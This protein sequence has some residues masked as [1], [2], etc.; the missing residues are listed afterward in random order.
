MNYQGKNK[1][2][3][4]YK[5]LVIMLLMISCSIFSQ[6]VIVDGDNNKIIELEIKGPSEKLSVTIVKAQEIKEYN[7][8]TGI[9]ELSMVKGGWDTDLNPYTYTWYKNGVQMSPQPILDQNNKINGLSHGEYHVIAKSRTCQATSNKINLTNPP[10]LKIS[11]SVHLPIACFEGEG[12]IRALIKG[13][14]SPSSGN[15]TVKLYK[16]GNT[17]ILPI[18]YVSYSSATNQVVDFGPLL[19]GNYRIEVSDKYI[20]KSATV[21]LVEP[22]KLST[23]IITPSD[24]SCNG[25]NDGKINVSITGGTIPYTLILDGIEQSVNFNSTK[26]IANLTAKNYSVQVRDANGCLSTIVPTKLEQPSAIKVSKVSDGNPTFAGASDGFIN[27]SVLGGTGVYFYQWFKNSSSTPFATTQNVSGLKEGSYKVVVTDS[28]NCNEELANIILTDPEPL[29]IKL[30]KSDVKCFGEASGTITANV[31]GGASS[32]YQYEWF[33]VEGTTNTTFG[34]N[35]ASVFNLG[36]GTYKVKVT[37][38][39]AGVPVEQKEK[40]IVINQPIQPLSIQETVA[41]VLCKGG[42]TGSIALNITGGTPGYTYEWSNGATTKDIG[43]LREGNYTVKITDNNRC[44]LEKTITIVEPLQELSVGLVNAQDPLAYGGTD[45][46]ININVTGGTFPYT[47][48]WFKDGATISIASTPN[49]TNIGKGR[50][51]VK[52][53]DTN[54]CSETLIHILDEPDPLVAAITIP[55]DGRLFCFNDT[56]GKMEVA[57]SGGLPP[58]AYHWYEKEAGGG[59]I[60]I[61][62]AT[63]TT[64]TN[65]ASGV[66]GIEVT[67]RNGNGVKT[68]TELEMINPAVVEISSS[69]VTNVACFGDTT[70]AIEV[71]LSGGSSSYLYQWTKQG[72]ADVIGTTNKL[73]NIPVGTYKLKVTDNLNCPNPAIEKTFTITQPEKLEIENDTQVNLSGFETNNGEIKVV[74]VK[75]G[76]LPYAYT[77][78]LK[79]SVAII[80]TTSHVTGLAAATYVMT[81]TDANNC[82][83]QKE[84][85][86]TQPDKLEVT[87]AIAD[88]IDCFGGRG[89]IRSNVSGGFLKTN[90]TYTYQWFDLNNPTTEIGSTFK[91]TNFSG[92]YMVKV[93]DSNGNTAQAQILLPQ[94]NPLAISYT[95]TAVS[96]YNGNDASITLSVT[97]GTNAYRYAWNNGMTTSTITALAAGRY[98]VVVKDDNNCEISATILISEPNEYKATPTVFNTPTGAGLSNGEIA[99]DVI[100]GTAPYQLEWRDED[101]NLLGNTDAIQNLSAGNYT[102]KVTDQLGCELVEVYNLGEPE[103][104][105]VTIEQNEEIQCKGNSQASLKAVANG[106]V[107]GNTYVWYSASTNNVLG[108]GQ[109]IYNLPSGNYYVVVTDFNNNASNS[110]SFFVAEPEILT[111]TLQSNATG[112]GMNNDWEITPIVKGGTPPYSYAWSSGETSAQLTDASLG[113]YFVLIT[114]ANGCQTTASITLENNSPLIINE[115][116]TDIKCYNKCSGAIN[117]DIEGGEA[118]FTFLW[119]NG[120]TTS[121]I[122]NICSGTYTVTV[123]DQKGCQMKKEFTLENPEE[124]AFELVPSE[125]TL[126]SGESIEYNVAQ[127]SIASY[128]WTSSNGFN[129]TSSN[130]ILSEEGVYTLTVKTNEGCEISKSITIN[131]SNAIIDA[132]FILTSQAF[133]GEDI[134]IINVSNPVSDTISWRIPTNVSLVQETT[135]GVVLRFP[136]PGS[137]EVSMISEEGNCRKMI[138][139]VVQVHKARTIEDIGDIEGPLVKE[140]SV[141]PNP[142]KGNFKVTITLEKEAEI[143]LRLFSLSANTIIEDQM[144]SGQKEYEVDYN[145]NVPPGI[146]IILLESAKTRRIAKVIIE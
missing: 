11:T 102:L 90:E 15:Y 123:T 41:N 29:V 13:G 128:K 26:T 19:V 111:A 76:V 42:D 89:T 38:L 14:F 134:V 46:S 54:G 8:N 100:G 125:V 141:F 98:T 145:I 45:G 27:V 49:L 121:S 70:G 101:L 71:A 32:T 110:Q 53:K 79:N 65:I 21:N 24:I 47:Y 16:N 142:N 82:I 36:I 81:I 95:K 23:P 122:A 75:G 87:L 56:D 61:S 91:L 118:P 22:T 94:N 93:T 124:F 103:P 58:Y 105:T 67:D 116:I 138:T 59:K 10:E 48:E 44:S 135:E 108:N 3:M 109:F 69:K 68:T 97:G 117:V 66:Y 55:S 64:L 34:T 86:I 126:C 80:G 143:S 7:T 74:A 30:N 92:T 60:F 140:F 119:N 114:D 1:N 139:K 63:G 18:K 85:T 39:L 17:S 2:T 73:S 57:V 35:T 106:G 99:V 28:N 33:K 129:S 96:C 25:G 133:V 72:Q 5:F 132:Q 77:L 12:H 136:A 113:T 51:E 120:A 50:Y 84:Y 20:K 127:S 78:R 107:G 88:P 43:G 146:Y 83:L 115:T 144:L 31:E 130:V 4:K 62:G 137:Y 52:V 40:S 112:C 37:V 131:A 6:T 104:L 9:I